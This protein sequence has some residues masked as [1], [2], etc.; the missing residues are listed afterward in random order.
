MRISDSLGFF[1]SRSRIE[2]ARHAVDIGAYAVIASNQGGRQFDSA[3]ATI[4]ML[5]E[6]ADAADEQREVI[7]DSGVRRGTHVL[8]ALALGA[9]ACMVGRPYLYGL[10]AGGEAGVNRALG[11]LRSA[12]ERD[13]ARGKSFLLNSHAA[14]YVGI[15]LISA[16]S[17][18]S[19]T[20][21]SWAICMRNH[22]PGPLPQNLPRRTAIS[23]VT[24]RSPARILCRLCRLTDISRAARAIVTFIA[25]KVI[26]RRMD[27]GCAGARFGLAI[28]CSFQLPAQFSDIAP[29]RPGKPLHSKIRR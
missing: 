20:Q 21:R 12:I 13:M 1:C 2:D 7:L 16:E 11:I 22:N 4:D 24:A 23:G 18:C 15:S 17:A 19:A 25:G 14:W 26:S 28:I 29:G 9:K 27:P 8:K 10:A 6:I 3:V 5:P